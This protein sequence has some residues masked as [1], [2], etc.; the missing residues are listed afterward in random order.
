MQ[1]ADKVID[2]S[3]A[4]V[5]ILKSDWDIYEIDEMRIPVDNNYRAFEKFS[6]RISY[7]IDTEN[8]Y[9]LRVRHRSRNPKVY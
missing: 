6:Y 7:K 9:I 3:V 8:I 1:I 2:A 5:E 4:S